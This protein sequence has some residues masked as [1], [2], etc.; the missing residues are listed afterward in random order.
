MRP[1]SSALPPAARTTSSTRPS[2]PSHWLTKSPT[3]TIC[4]A[5][6]RI[7]P[8]FSA[9]MPWF[10]PL[11]RP[12]KVEGLIISKVIASYLFND[13]VGSARKSA[14]LQHGLRNFL[15][16]DEPLLLGRREHGGQRC[17]R[18]LAGLG[19]DTRD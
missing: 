9:S 17:L 3:G 18:C 10:Q 8:P 11:G 16:R 19:R 13:S 6:K 5:M 1:M 4:P 12:P 7:R 2:A 15:R 14:Q